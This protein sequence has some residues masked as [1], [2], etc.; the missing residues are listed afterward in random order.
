MGWGDDTVNVVDRF[1]ISCKNIIVRIAAD[2]CVCDC[3]SSGCALHE[4]NK[5]PT[6]AV[7]RTLAESANETKAVIIFH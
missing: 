6:S 3:V 1:K 5:T 2:V 4:L 7:T